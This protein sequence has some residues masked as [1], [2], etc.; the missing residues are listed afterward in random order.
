MPL[1]LDNTMDLSSNIGEQLVPYFVYTHSDSVTDT[2]RN[3]NSGTL[4]PSSESY[5]NFGSL[6]IRSKRY[7]GR[8]FLIFKDNASKDHY[9]LYYKYSKEIYGL[10]SDKIFTVPKIGAIITF[11]N[12]NSFEKLTN[13]YASKIK[14]V[15][16][17]DGANDFLLNYKIEMKDSSKIFNNVPLNSLPRNDGGITYYTFLLDVNGIH[18]GFYENILE[19][20]TAHQFLINTNST[21]VFIAGELK[22]EG[23]AITFNFMSGTFSARLRLEEKPLLYY[24]YKD[25]MKNIF[26]LHDNTIKTRFT[27]ITFTHDVLFPKIKPSINSVRTMCLKPITSRNVVKI[28]DGVRCVN[29]SMADLPLGEDDLA[30]DDLRLGRNLLCE[31][32][33][34]QYD[35]KYVSESYKNKYIKYKNKYLNLKKQL[36]K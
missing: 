23:Q 26:D 20:G 6:I 32:A 3:I 22:I 14:C 2:I 18:Y 30:E 9:L 25:L 13:P 34:Y 35:K 5:T 11:L 17:P 31:D 19:M 36:N 15:N 12:T 16:N 27:S 10:L 33:T 1:T 24:L 7:D 29:N 8:P 21:N 28:S 4:V